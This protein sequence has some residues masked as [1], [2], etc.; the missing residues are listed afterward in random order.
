MSDPKKVPSEPKKDELNDEEL[1]GVSG[2][3]IDA[4]LDF[5]RAGPTVEPGTEKK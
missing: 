4:F 5:T 3:A 2:G 1:D